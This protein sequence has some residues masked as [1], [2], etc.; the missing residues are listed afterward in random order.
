MHG[1]NHIGSGAIADDVNQED[2][3]VNSWEKQDEDDV[4][5]QHPTTTVPDQLRTLKDELGEG[6]EDPD[7]TDSVHSTLDDTDITQQESRDTSVISHPRSSEET[8]WAELQEI[9]EQESKDQVSEN[10]SS[11][12]DL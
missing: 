1:S 3:R 5:T 10:V 9:E 8:N 6:D 2:D 4:T 7:D 12:L 11:F